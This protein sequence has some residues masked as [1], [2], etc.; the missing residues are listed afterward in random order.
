MWDLYGGFI[1]LGFG[2]TIL[3]NLDYLI[4]A[5]VALA[6]IPLIIRNRVVVPRLGVVKF[7]LERQAK[8]KKS[9]LAA[10]VVLTLTTM[11]G[12]VFFILYAANAMPHW[13]E[14]W[15]HDHFLTFFGGMVAVLI[16]AAAFLVSV[17]RFYLYAITVFVAFFLASTLR[18]QDMEGIPITVAGGLILSLGI[19]I[20]VRFLRNHPQPKEEIL[21]GN[22]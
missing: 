21:N 1:L 13:L 9:K 19:V 22:G 17:K 3:T 15:M 18:S 12:M 20:L 8:T 11:L 2:L 4:V 10:M 5:F 6:M 7:S 16:L 14:I